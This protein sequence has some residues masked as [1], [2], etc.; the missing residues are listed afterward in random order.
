MRFYNYFSNANFPQVR[1][2]ASFQYKAALAAMQLHA[3][4]LARCNAVPGSL[5]PSS[6]ESSAP[7][8]LTAWQEYDRSILLAQHGSWNRNRP[9]GARVMRVVLDATRAAVGSFT[10]F[11]SGALVAGVPCSGSATSLAG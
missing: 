6:T 10:P 2:P 7:A 3:S 4:G 8:P 11:L 5:G 9:I 1:P